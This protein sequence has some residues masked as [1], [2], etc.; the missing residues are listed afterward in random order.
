VVTY[1]PWRLSDHS[2]RGAPSVS[3]RG[4]ACRPGVGTEGVNRVAIGPS[5]HVTAQMTPK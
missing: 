3:G 4:P 5:A 1:P 2:A